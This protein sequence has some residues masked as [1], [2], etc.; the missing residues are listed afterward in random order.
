[1][2]ELSLEQERGGVNVIK[3]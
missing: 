2:T 3:T 1:M